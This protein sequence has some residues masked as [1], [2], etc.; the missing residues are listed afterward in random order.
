MPPDIEQRGLGRQQKSD[1]DWRSSRVSH[2]PRLQSRLARALLPKASPLSRRESE[3]ERRHAPVTHRLFDSRSWSEAWRWPLPARPV[4][5]I[6]KP[7]PQSL[8]SAALYSAGNVAFAIGTTDV[9]LIQLVRAVKHR[10]GL[11]ALRRVGRLRA[12]AIRRSDP[13]ARSTRGVCTRLPR[14]NL[15]RAR[16]RDPGRGGDAD[17]RLGERHL[18]HRANDQVRRPA[19]ARHSNGAARVLRWL[20]STRQSKEHRERAR[21]C[22][23]SASSFWRRST[24]R[25]SPPVCSTISIWL[26]WA[27]W[28]RSFRYRQK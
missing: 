7:F 20:T 10:G 8:S 1:V 14:G 18:S 24:K 16:S 28:R 11:R 15:P 6:S 5:G 26:T 9:R 13:R 4:G 25:S 27:F 3:D 12:K 19:D 21:T 17:D 2:R 22:W 23:A